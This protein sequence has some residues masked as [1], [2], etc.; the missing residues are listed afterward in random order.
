[1]NTLPDE[2]IASIKVF[3]MGDDKYIAVKKATEKRARYN[4][5]I[6]HFEGKKWDDAIGKPDKSFERNRAR[7]EEIM[8][9]DG[10]CV[11][12]NYQT[13]SETISFKEN[14]KLYTVSVSFKG[15]LVKTLKI[16]KAELSTYK[17]FIYTCMR[18]YYDKRFCESVDALRALE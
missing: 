4:T 5:M 11:W 6:R 1:M 18:Q 15:G 17:D 9:R 16:N 3:V 13:R 10:R 8:A 2:L 7:Y 14:K 12:I